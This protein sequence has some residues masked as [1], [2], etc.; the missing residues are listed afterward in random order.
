MLI[1]CYLRQLRDGLTIGN[2]GDI[3][4]VDRETLQ[5]LSASIDKPKTMHLTTCEIERR[6]SGI[7]NAPDSSHRVYLKATVEIVFSI[8]QIVVWFWY[9]R[10]VIRGRSLLCCH[11]TFGGV[12][13]PIGLREL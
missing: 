7:R 13:I 4:I 2:N 3:M 12:V 1:I 10:W 9:S 6:N 5:C 11:D 8:D